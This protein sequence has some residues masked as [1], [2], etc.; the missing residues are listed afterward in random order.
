MRFSVSTAPLAQ[1]ATIASDI[2]AGPELSGLF[3]IKLPTSLVGGFGIPA[4]VLIQERAT[5]LRN[6]PCAKPMLLAN[7][8]D[9]EKQ[10]LQE[11]SPIGS[12]NMQANAEL[13]VQVVGAALVIT[14][15]ERKWWAQALRGLHGLR[16]ASLD[17]FADYVL[18]TRSLIQDGGL[19][20]C[21]ALNAVSPA[22]PPATS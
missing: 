6:A 7:M 1:T 3:D 8:G 5:Y 15:D 2:L 12:P 11:V 17:H 4:H 20:V 21:D 18:R 16:L 10:S 14:E 19:L 22:R 13:W 9:D